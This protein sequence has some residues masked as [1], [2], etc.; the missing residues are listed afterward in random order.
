MHDLPVQHSLQ[1]LVIEDD[2]TTRLLLQRTLEKEGYNVTLAEDGVQGMD[3]ALSISPALIISDWVMPELD[4]MELCRQVRSHPQLSGIFVILLSSRETVADRVEGLDAG[5]D[6]FLSKPIDP[7]ELKARVRAGLRQ[8][9][10]NHQLKAANYD[11]MLTLQKLQQAQ[12]QL[13]QSE[14]MSSL[15]QMVAG[16]AHEINNPINFIEGNLSF[17]EDYIQDLLNIIYLY[18]KYFPDVPEDLQALL[19]D[20][21]IEFLTEDSK[22]LIDSMRVGASRIH[23]IINHLRNFSRLDEADMKRVDIHDGINSTLIMLQNRLRIGSG[24][25]IEVHKHYGDLPKIDCYPGQLNQVFLNILHNAIYFLQEYVKNGDLTNPKIE[26]STRCIEAE[27]TVEINI[28]NNGSSIP[29]ATI[30][31]VFDP[32]FTTKPVGQGTGM[33][34]SICYQI[35]AERHRGH[36][37]CFTPPDGGTGFAIEI[38]RRQPEE[39]P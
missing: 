19:E 27:D 34:L 28:L 4:G 18:Q 36:I 16:I 5:A 2:A 13:I 15:G 25:E 3:K 26:I 9:Q 32:F 23:K 38:P 7:N 8:Y 17:A 39:N 20:T 37:R 10:L 1:I 6:E 12:A 35:I 22:Q 33:G 11:L 24:V 30:S 29:E 21:D 14:K 31:K